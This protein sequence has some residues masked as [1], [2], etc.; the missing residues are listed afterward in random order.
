MAATTNRQRAQIKTKIK[1]L[2]VNH[3]KW[4][5]EAS[6]ASEK[7]S[8]VRGEI[9]SL[10]MSNDIEKISVELDDGSLLAQVSI[11]PLASRR[12]S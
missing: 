8:E 4:S 11:W 5:T 2:I 3:N 12:Q 1:R 6:N 9:Q 7:A 10:M